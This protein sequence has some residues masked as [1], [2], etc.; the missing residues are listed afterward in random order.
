MNDTHMPCPE[1]Y[2][3]PTGNEWQSLLPADQEIPGRYKAG[4]GETIAATLHIG[5]GTLITPS[6]GVTGTQ[7]YVKFTSEDTGRSLII[8]LAGSKGDK[9]SSNNPAFGKRAC[10]VDKRT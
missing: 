7:H 4:N 2:R 5:E 1:G 3:I 6:S 9:S 8:P 10:V